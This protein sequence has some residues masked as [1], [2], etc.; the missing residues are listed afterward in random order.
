MDIRG[1]V[2][3]FG[4]NKQPPDPTMCDRICGSICLMQRRAKQ[5]KSGLSRNQ[6]SK[7][8]DKYVVSSSLNQMMNNSNTPW[9]TLVESW[10]FRCQQKCHVKHQQI[11]AGNLP[12]YW[13]TQDQICLYCR[14]RRIYENTIR[15]CAA[16]VSRRSHLCKRNFFIEPLQF[17]T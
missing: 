2:R 16:K 4:G 14:C 7:M 13:E 10:K 3:D 11:A 17:G 6:S 15:R 8:P 1:P 12:Q 9:K 5:S